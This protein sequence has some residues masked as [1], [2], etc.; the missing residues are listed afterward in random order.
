L[1]PF[2]SSERAVAFA[3][4]QSARWQEEGR[5]VRRMGALFLRGSKRFP[6]PFSNAVLAPG[7]AALGPAWLLDAAEPIFPD[8]RYVL[9]ARQQ[10]GGELGRLA[11][12]RGFQSL[13]HSPAM[14]CR[15]PPKGRTARGVTVQAVT[16]HEAL[17]QFVHICARAYAENGI[18]EA[19]THSL[20]AVRDAVLARALLAMAEVAGRPA[21]AALS[22][23][24]P[25]SG[26]GGVFWVGTLPEARRLGAAS[27]VTRVVTN[28]AFDAGAELVVLQASQAGQP[29]YA[30]LGYEEVG[31]HALFLSPSRRDGAR[32]ATTGGSQPSGREQP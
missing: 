6:T 14:I 21:A 2:T 31:H 18:P 11:M 4:A 29:V 19:V 15:K 17:A 22:L 23:V 13:G 27:A 30:R 16:T 20:F 1:D 9:W 26:I 8:R 28:A 3:L 12:R 10:D 7:A 5:L 32:P 25:G 24:E